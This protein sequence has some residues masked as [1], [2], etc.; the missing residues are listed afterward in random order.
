MQLVFFDFYCI[1]LFQMPS[2][3][4]LYVF[5]FVDVKVSLV[6]HYC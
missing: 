4:Y 5:V 3:S 2:S 6:Y 1:L